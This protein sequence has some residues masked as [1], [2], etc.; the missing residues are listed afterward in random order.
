MRQR[1]EF[2]ATD[3]WSHLQSVVEPLDG[4]DQVETDALEEALQQ[5]LGLEMGEKVE[6]WNFDWDFAVSSIDGQIKFSDEILVESAVEVLAHEADAFP[7]LD[8]E[9]FAVL[10]QQLEIE[11]NLLGFY[12]YLHAQ[13]RRDRLMYPTEE[14]FQS[15]R[16]LGQWAAY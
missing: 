6:G 3:I 15:N 9:I 11:G 7:P 16:V 14:E 4:S 10:V 13:Y 5:L 12:I 8:A 1:D 2:V